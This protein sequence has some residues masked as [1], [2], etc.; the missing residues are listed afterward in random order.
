MEH[1]SRCLCRVSCTQKI[2]TPSLKKG[3]HR[4]GV[5]ATFN[6]I[7]TF[8][9]GFSLLVFWHLIASILRCRASSRVTFRMVA[10]GERVATKRTKR[11][12]SR[13]GFKRKRHVDHT[14]ERTRKRKKM[15]ELAL[16]RRP[17][18]DILRCWASSRVLFHAGDGGRGTPR[19]EENEAKQV[20]TRPQAEAPRRPRR[21]AHSKAEEA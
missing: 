16:F 5:V 17:R 7:P 19:D 8:V 20:S 2:Q 14:V 13:R 9:I 4:A 3:L 1:L 10:V 12:K 15:L 11:S 6:T 21:R 18:T